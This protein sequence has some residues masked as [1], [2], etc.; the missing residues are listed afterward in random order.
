MRET[1]KSTTLALLRA[2][3][4]VALVPELATARLFFGH[5]LCWLLVVVALALSKR[6]R[7]RARGRRPFLE[8]SSQVF[9]IYEYKSKQQEIKER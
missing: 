2:L 1:L 8:P 3:A 5:T 6:G 4:L 7:P 9:P